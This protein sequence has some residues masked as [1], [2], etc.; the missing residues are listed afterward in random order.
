MVTPYAHEIEQSLLGACINEYENLQDTVDL[1][2]P[3][4]FY[5]ER[6]RKIYEALVKI[7]D[8][9]VMLLEQELKD[10]GQLDEVG[11]DY[12]TI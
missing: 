10:R 6:N 2:E 7:D 3:E 5:L 8:N 9:N 11:R 12:Y 1:I 4:H